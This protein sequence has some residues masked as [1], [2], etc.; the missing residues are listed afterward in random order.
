MLSAGLPNGSP[1]DR[2]KV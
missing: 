1:G 2:G